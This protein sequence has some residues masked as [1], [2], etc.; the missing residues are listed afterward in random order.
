MHAILTLGVL[1]AAQQLFNSM[2]KTLV[3]KVVV[4][5]LK[6]DL[7][8]VSQTLCWYLNMQA[9]YGH[10]IEGTLQSVDQVCTLLHVFVAHRA[11]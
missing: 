9:N 2:F 5:E 7:W 11:L 8:C 1:T 10:S 6:N 4:V 3:G